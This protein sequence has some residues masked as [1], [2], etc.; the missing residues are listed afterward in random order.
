MKVK[1]ILNNYQ[2]GAKLQSAPTH[3]LIR[4]ERIDSRRTEVVFDI[5]EGQK[6]FCDKLF[7]RMGRV[8][9]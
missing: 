5:S 8:E 4:R 1:Y 3:K 2:V 9:E 6:E 7:A